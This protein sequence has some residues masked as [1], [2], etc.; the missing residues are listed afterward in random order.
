LIGGMRDRG[1]FSAAITFRKPLNKLL[2]WIRQY[3]RQ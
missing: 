1:A 2:I 3:H